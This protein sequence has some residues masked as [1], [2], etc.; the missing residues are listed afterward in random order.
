MRLRIILPLILLMFA[1]GCGAKDKKLIETESELVQDQGTSQIC[2]YNEVL[3][4]KGK[5]SNYTFIDI[6]KDNEIKETINT[7][8][9][10]D[11][12][13]ELGCFDFNDD[14][15][16]DIAVIGTSGSETKVLLYE[17]TSEYQY[18][19]FSGWSDVG[20][21]I[22]ESLG[23]DFSM[24]E[25]KDILGNYWSSDRAMEV[26]ETDDWSCEAGDYKEAYA[27]IARIFESGY[28]GVKYD[29][30]DIDGKE[31]LEFVISDV[32]FV[33]LF[34]YEGGY[35]HKFLTGTLG[36]VAS[37]AYEYSPGKS[38]IQHL[39]GNSP[40]VTYYKEYIPVLEG[41]E[42]GDRV[43]FLEC[44]IKDFDGDGEITDKE[45]VMSS[46]DSQI[47]YETW[48]ENWSEN[49]MSDDELKKLVDGYSALDYEDLYGYLSFDEFIKKLE[50][51]EIEEKQET[52]EI[53]YSLYEEFVE[54]LKTNMKK[55]SLESLYDI[56]DEWDLGL[57]EGLSFYVKDNP[58]AESMWYLQK[59]IDGD[60]VDELLFGTGNPDVK[61]D[62]WRGDDYICDLF[63]IRNRKLLHVFKGG[64]RS[65]YYL[66]ENGIIENEAA[67]G[68]SMD[69][70]FYRYNNGELKF[71]EHIFNEP[72]YPDA[73]RHCY[74]YV[75]KD[76]I[77]RELT[78]KEYH[79]MRDEL[80]H[81]YNRPKLQ[82]NPFKEK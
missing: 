18:D 29:L 73:D 24:N 51:E 81:K 34:N 32:G 6:I 66:C 80:E 57:S 78:E 79:D 75:N 9:Y 12:V 20:A 30:V 15:I 19:V 28:K 69:Q 74:Y 58:Y 60:G 71:I 77:A 62:I 52:T 8:R 21:V 27:S 10:L 26:L 48:Y 7:Y 76:C 65:R 43:A 2:V 14:G 36:V 4:A 55:E 41:F 53:D 61:L 22:N 42:F 37:N 44:N 59:D 64:C 56:V 1:T 13:K 33:A 49:E 47:A 16:K 17:A 31:P 63:T 3:T 46:P 23:D 35:A 70:A 45:W 67:N 40:T 68:S 72:D 38:I 11:S 50:N 82:L 54:S 25:L 39:G 5:K